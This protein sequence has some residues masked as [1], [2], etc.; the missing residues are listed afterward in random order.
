MRKAL[1]AAR[2]AGRPGPAARPPARRA[3]ASSVD[4]AVQLQRPGQDLADRHARIE[5]GIGVLEDHLHAPAQRPDLRL[6][7]VGDVGAVE[8]HPSGGRLVQPRDQPRQGGFAAAGFADQPDRLAAHHLSDR[9]RPR[10]AGRG[11]AAKQRR[12]AAAR[13]A[14]SRPVTSSSGVACWPRRPAAALRRAAVPA[15][16]ARRR[17]ASP[18]SA[19]A[20]S[21]PTG[22]SAGCSAHCV[23]RERAAGAEAAAGR[24]RRADRAA[25]PRWWPAGGPAPRRRCAAPRAAAPRCRDGAGR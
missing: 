23:D 11:A 12:R 2:A 16:A 5:R 13:N 22:S 4:D 1:G 15:C 17:A 6:G 7:R 19:T 9:R 21:S 8:Q 18:S 3:A 25:G 14:C 10:R 24:A 20:R